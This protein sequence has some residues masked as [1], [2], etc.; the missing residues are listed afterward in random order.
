M[1]IQEKF[2]DFYRD[3]GLHSIDKLEGIYHQNVKFVDPVG[4]HNGLEQVKHYFSHLLTSTQSCEFVV[5]TLLSKDD[6]ALARWQMK[7]RHPKIGNG[8]EVVLDGV[9]E[10]IIVNGRIKQQTDFYDMGTMI[11]EHLPILGALVRFI[12]RKMQNI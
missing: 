11:Y 10:L 1:T 2:I 8:E 9:S 3:L 12:K 6:T 7:M 5:T 4:E